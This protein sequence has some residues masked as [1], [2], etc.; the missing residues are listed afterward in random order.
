MKDIGEEAEYLYDHHCKLR[1]PSNSTYLCRHNEGV[2]KQLIENH[3][4][5]DEVTFKAYLRFTP[6]QFTFLLSLI[7]A[8]LTVASLQ[9]CENVYN[10]GREAGADVEVSR[11]H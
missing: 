1:K 7:E 9:S 3:L 5:N 4:L 6:Q 11:K 2:S 10:A 8:E